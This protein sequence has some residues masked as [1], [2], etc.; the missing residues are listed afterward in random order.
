MHEPIIATFDNNF[1]NIIKKVYTDKYGFTNE[2]C[3]F[4]KILNESSISDDE[5]AS[6]RQIKIIG[7]DRNS[8]FYDDYHNFIDS[9]CLFNDIFYKFITDYVK[10][11]YAVNGRI[12]VQKTPNIRISFPNTTAIGKHASENESDNVIGLHKDSDFGH[13]PSEVNFIIPL[14]DMFD[15]NS[16]YYEPYIGSGLSTNE[17][18]N[19]KLSSNEFFICKFN[20]LLHFNKIN[21]TGVTRMSL[22][23]RII[24]YDKYVENEE[25]FKNTK[26]ELGRYYIVL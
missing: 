21:D 16:I 1:I 12:V 22:D 11:L 10:P 19:L 17:F 4:H 20:Q 2:L 7:K 14:T 8:V 24:P 23:F 6:T 13:H 5:K 18:L 9:T 25:Y 3:N 15:T 26:F